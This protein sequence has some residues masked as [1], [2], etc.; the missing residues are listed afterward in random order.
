MVNKDERVKVLDLG[1][2]RYAGD[3]VNLTRGDAVLGLAA[4][5]APEQASNSHSVDG[6]AD[7]YG[8]GATFYLAITG[9]KPP[10][11]GK[12]DPPPARAPSEEPDYQKLM[13]VVKKMMALRPEDRYQSARDVIAVLDEMGCEVVTTPAPLVLTPEPMPEP[14]RSGATGFRQ[15][16]MPEVATAPTPVWAAPTPAPMASPETGT[17]PI[18][19]AE[20]ITHLV[21]TPGPNATAAD[22]P[23]PKWGSAPGHTATPF[24]AAA[25]KT[26]DAPVWMTLVNQTKPAAQPKPAAP[27]P[28][29][30][31]W[32]KWAFLAF[33][34]LGFLAALAY[35]IWG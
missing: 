20:T 19:A 30:K 12:F 23:L 35:L 18:T 32:G 10:V 16:A 29:P 13:G 5:I 22:L 28:E 7:L 2:A 17:R 31:P 11:Y 1:L 25:Q 26:H 27:P 4:Y 21:E 8:L 6:R 15:R 14:G 9:K 3:D 33:G 24:G 34:V